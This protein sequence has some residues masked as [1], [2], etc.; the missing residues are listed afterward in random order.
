VV[1]LAEQ[2]LAQL[3]DEVAAETPAPGGG[4]SA[5]CACALGA[6]LVEMA[7][8]LGIA[9]GADI[10]ADVPDRARA[11]RERGLAL[12]E[13]ELSSYAP[14]LEALRRPK[15]DPERPARLDAAL[16]AAAESPL[17]IAEAAADTAALGTQ[18]AARSSPSVRG[19][20]LS[21]AVL[22]EAAAAAA[23]AL[24]EINLEGRGD[25]YRLVRARGARRRAGEARAR[26][27]AI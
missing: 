7:A 15:D 4:S 19:D 2:P 17:A 3:L 23:A 8:R 25:D 24:V 21:G 1:R 5:A 27:L 20:A 18:V 26:A 9:R 12:A 16:S 10:P 11:L 6:A 13:R 22:G 14:V